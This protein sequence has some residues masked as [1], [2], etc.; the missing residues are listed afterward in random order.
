MKDLRPSEVEKRKRTN[1]SR[2]KNIQMNS[3]GKQ[4]K[5]RHPK[6]KHDLIIK[7]DTSR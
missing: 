3:W 7:A 4:K 1:V 6:S 2:I 5:K